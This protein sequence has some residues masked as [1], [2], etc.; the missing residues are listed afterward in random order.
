MYP[1]IGRIYSEMGKENKLLF[2]NLEIISFIYP[3]NP[4]KYETR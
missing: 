2:R 4:K 3:K 1:H